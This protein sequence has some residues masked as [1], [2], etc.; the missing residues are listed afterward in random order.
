MR[1]VQGRGRVFGGFEVI[2]DV[3]FHGGRWVF[4]GTIW[5]VQLFSF[6]SFSLTFV[7]FG[8][9]SCQ[10]RSACIFRFSCSG[11]MTIP[12]VVTIFCLILKGIFIE[13]LKGKY[14]HAFFL[15]ITLP[16]TTHGY[17]LP[18]FLNRLGSSSNFKFAVETSFSSFIPHPSKNAI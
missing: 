1:E 9:Y 2:I 8:V 16:L 4:W 11:F 3:S 10:V 7:G 5:G 18:S 14:Y 12:V 13:F 17:Q 15:S 6:S